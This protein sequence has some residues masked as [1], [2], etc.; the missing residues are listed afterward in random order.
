LLPRLPLQ[1]RYSWRDIDSIRAAAVARAAAQRRMLRGIGTAFH[2]RA[3]ATAAQQ[4]RAQAAS[5]N[6]IRD[7]IAD[8]EQRVKTMRADEATRQRDYL[9]QLKVWEWSR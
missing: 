3:A 1:V 9:A 5:R 8:A 2:R 6:E 4:R 7:A